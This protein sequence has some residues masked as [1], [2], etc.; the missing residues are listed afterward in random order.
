VFVID[1]SAHLRSVG[2]DLRQALTEAGRP[3]AVQTFAW[4]HGP[5]RVLADLH[6]HEHQRTKGHELAAT[7][8]SERQ[9]HPGRKVYLVCHSSGAAIVIAAAQ[10]LPDNSVQRIILLAPA[11]SPGCDV[12]PLLRCAHAVDSFHSA[13]DLIGG[14][15]LAVMGNA[16][17]SFRSSAGCVG[18]S[19]ERD[20]G[21]ADA[22]YGNLRQHAWDWDMTRTGY[23]GGHFGCTRSGFLRQYVVPLLE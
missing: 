17:G 13:S 23:H 9:S 8:V 14:L 7:V 19:P 18:F 2:E 15:V 12:K 20:G 4:S 21:P 1:G 22:L 16:D 11:V 10:E 6:G 5:G 3:H